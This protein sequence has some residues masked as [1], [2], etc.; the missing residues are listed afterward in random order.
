MPATSI[1]TFFA[2]SL[3]VILVVSTMAALPKVLH[4]FLDGLSHKNDAE[5]FQQLAQYL[6]LNTGSPSDWGSNRDV[7][8]TIFGL[9]SNST[10]R[11][12]T[13]DID[14]VTR[15][16]ST[17]V[18]AITYAQ[19]LDALKLS[20]IA[21]RISIQPIFDT[22]INLTSSVNNGDETSY[23]FDIITQ[24]SGLAVVSNLS[25][26]LVVRDYLDNLFSSTNLSG[27]AN[28][29]FTVPNNVNGSA[30]LIVFAKAHVN[31]SAVSF[32]VYSF[33]HNASSPRQNGVFVRP[34]PLGYVLN[35]SFNYPNEQILGAF[36]LSYSYRANLT[37]LSNATQTAEYSF[38]HFLGKSATILVLI[39]LNGT[40]S[41]A[42]WVAYPQVPL[43]IGV[44]FDAS[45]LHSTVFSFA[46]IVTIDSVFF[47]FQIKCRTVG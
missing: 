26:Y 21:L 47:E 27:K 46:Y 15:L 43:D 37:L 29:T 20:N 18:F 34:N 42:E 1:D 39:G 10:S 44:N 24:K 28:V 16:N 17:N 19:L 25:C 11:P 23:N 9:A 13:L 4:P 32:G 14:K 38:P 12:Y 5:L 36:A 41:F 40:E 2:C 45:I 7:S 8:P 30:L 35:V 22:S 33:G 6:L 3:L 31:P